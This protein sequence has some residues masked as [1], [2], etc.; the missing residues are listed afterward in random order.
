MRKSTVKKTVTKAPVNKKETVKTEQ[1]MLRSQ[2]SWQ[3]EAR[4]N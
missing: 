3:G 1:E 2:M 4:K